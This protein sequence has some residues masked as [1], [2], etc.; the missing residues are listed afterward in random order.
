MAN[1]GH[2][3]SL[4]HST[5]AGTFLG[6]TVDIGRL[7]VD[8]RRVSTLGIDKIWIAFALMSTLTAGDGEFEVF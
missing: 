1:D 3:G 8:L 5:L 7:M 4:Q 6:C 2:R